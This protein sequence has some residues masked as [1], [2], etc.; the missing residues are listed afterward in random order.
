MKKS[1]KALL[2]TIV[3]VLGVS[4]GVA[5]AVAGVTNQKTSVDTNNV[6]TPGSATTMATTSSSGVANKLKIVDQTYDVVDIGGKTSSIIQVKVSGSSNLRYDWQI[7]RGTGWS[8]YAGGPG[9]YVTRVSPGK[10]STILNWTLKC[11]ITD[12]KTGEKITS[13]DIKVT[14]LPESGEYINITKQP[15]AKKTVDGGQEVEL[16]TEAIAIGEYSGKTVGYQ[17][18]EYDSNEDKFT[19]IKDATNSSYTFIAP[20]NTK[21]STIKKYVCKYY[22]KDSSQT[23]EYLSESNQSIVT[24]KRD[25][26]E[27]I[28]VTLSSNQKVKVDDEITLSVVATSTKTK[29]EN[30]KY[31]WYEAD[32]YGKPYKLIK[33]ATSSEYKYKA[34]KADEGKLLFFCVLVTGS[35]QDG[36]LN[37]FQS[38]NIEVEVLSS[39]GTLGSATNGTFASKLSVTSS[40]TTN[41]ASVRPTFYPVSGI[42]TPTYSVEV[43]G[44]DSV[45]ELTYKWYYVGRDGKENLIEGSVDSVL[46]TSKSLYEK[47][48]KDNSYHKVGIKCEIYKGK[49]L[50]QTVD[51]KTD[52]RF[53]MTVVIARR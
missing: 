30:L 10:T 23:K 44:V 26:K 28:K 8:V 34:T 19:E 33:D 11:V 37:H 1:K 43:K 29:E 53:Y 46:T 27:E 17:W 50:V 38:G 18:F 25:V 51:Q 24:I 13:E 48:Y 20:S 12:T 15:E 36:E 39:N 2:W 22:I 4:S 45:S 14:I 5:G 41:Q 40:V 3:P 32:V 35:I 49:Q 7:N 31:Q 42:K 21:A 52:S 9:A 47:V 16:T 6:A